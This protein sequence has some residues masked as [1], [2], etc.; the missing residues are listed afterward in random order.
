[1]TLRIIGAGL[2][3]TGTTSLKAAL[4]VL[5]GKP[6]YHMFEV[7]QRPADVAHWHAAA[8]GETPDWADFL[9]GYAAAVDWPSSAFWPEL[10]SAFPDAPIL[11][12]T[13][14]SASWWR[15]V[16][17]TIFPAIGRADGPW[18]EMIDTLFAARFVTDL[19]DERACIAAYETH[20]ADVRRRVPPARLIDWQIADGWGP[21]CSALGLPQPDVEFPHANSTAEFNA[22][23]GGGAPG[24]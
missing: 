16:S 6:C 3:R 23:H 10:A 18:R 8:R 1:M 2:G 14:D 11:L 13:R 4:E 5:L 17:D 19:R 22:R 20:N 21:L 9:D 12:S 24:S 7:L 15:S